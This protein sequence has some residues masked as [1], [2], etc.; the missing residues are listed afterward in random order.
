VRWGVIASLRPWTGF[1]LRIANWFERC[2]SDR[3]GMIVRV[4]GT[5]HDKARLER[6][7]SLLA[8]AGEGPFVPVLAAASLV[9]RAASGESI[10]AGARPCLGE[11]TLAQLQSAMAGLPISMG[12]A[13]DGSDHRP[14]LYRR[15]LGARFE[16]MPAALRELHDM[17]NGDAQGLAQI[18]GAANALGRLIARL[19][20]F[21]HSASDVPTTVRFTSRDGRETWQRDFAGHRF[22]SIQHMGAGRWAGLLVERF[23]PVAFAM[24]VPVS[25]QGLDLKIVAGTFLGVPLPRFCFPVIDAGERVDAQGRFRFDVEIGL[26][27][28]GRLV[29]YRGWLEPGPSTKRAPSAASGTLQES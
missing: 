18:D 19:F 13:A 9:R 6:Q 8:E 28:I 27:V 26:R 15:V 4:S 22:K 24:Q 3:G 17:N 16:Q 12:W 14:S 11:V 20:R 2:G 1:L 25:A 5:G 7:W 23:G 21:P 10:A 29:R